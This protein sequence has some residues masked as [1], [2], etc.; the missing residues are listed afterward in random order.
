MSRL[1]D[2]LKGHAFNDSNISNNYHNT[3]PNHYTY[4]NDLTVYNPPNIRDTVTTTSY[5]PMMDSNQKLLNE[6][7]EL[8]QTLDYLMKFLLMKGILK[9]ENEFKDFIAA[10]ELANKLAEN[11]KK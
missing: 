4:P 7:I 11:N 1:S 6:I 3:N 2:Y 9:D 8:N 10:I 5:W